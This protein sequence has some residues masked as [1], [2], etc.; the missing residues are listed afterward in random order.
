M[1]HDWPDPERQ[2]WSEEAE[3]GVIGALL[4]KP[5]L[6]E[7]MG[8]YLL[9]V[10]FNFEDS[11]A[12]YAM[13]LAERSKGRSADP[14]TLSDIRSTLPSG[15][16][17]LIFAAN[18]QRNVPSAANAMTYAKVVRD[19]YQARQLHRI[20]GEIMGLSMSNG[21]VSSQIAQ[22]QEMLLGLNTEDERP[23]VITMRE[24]MT[25]IVD[26]M[27][28]RDQQKEP[29][30]RGI[31]WGLEDLDKIIKGLFPGN[32]VVVAGRPGTG[33]TVLGLQL[34]DEI[35]VRRGRSAMVFSL[36][37]EAAE[38]AK[39]SLSANSGVL[40]DKIDGTQQTEDNDWPKLTSGVN[41]I[42]HAD[43]RL[44]EKPSLPFSRIASI[45]RFQHRVKPL[46]VIV[47]DYIGLISPEPGSRL[48]N[49]TAELGV[50]S[51][52][53]KALAKEL[54]IPIVVLAQLNR[55][56]EGRLVK[57]PIMSD[58]RDCGDIE[59]DA[60]IIIFAHRDELTEDGRD[61]ITDI[62]VE[63]V[64][65]AK[66]GQCRLKFRGEIARFVYAPKSYGDTEAPSNFAAQGTA[67]FFK[68]RK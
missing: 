68:G 41:A 37:M 65:H 27:T 8:S 2:L 51:R 21:T 32:M 39:R 26:R 16:S 63:K 10:H 12:L 35:A 22:A 58:L 31:K 59:Q 11:A 43:Y 49:R 7:E 42:V 5:Q 24:A 1:S 3:N 13:I 45:A 14:V 60:D 50:V 28:D 54:K 53:I 47:I 30:E 44:C 57:R 15:E 29:E 38:L 48:F 23:D 18:I 64:R 36:E 66:V 67:G 19:R 17:T 20:A 4:I 40:Q 33:K 62:F 9:P 34:A 61:G 6:A 25:P 56:I 52:G 55:A 46:D